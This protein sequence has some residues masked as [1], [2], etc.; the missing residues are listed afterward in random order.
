MVPI[1][2]AR[3]VSPIRLALPHSALGALDRSGLDANQKPGLDQFLQE[4]TANIDELPVF[5]SLPH[6]KA[7]RFGVYPIQTNE[8]SNESKGAVQVDTTFIGSSIAT[9]NPGLINVNTS[10]V[11]LV[12]AAMRTAGMGGLEQIIQARSQGKLANAPSPDPRTGNDEEMKV[13]LTSVSSVWSFRI[14]VEVGPL[15]RSWWAVYVRNGSQWECVQRL[16]IP[17]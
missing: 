12:E 8:S 5:P 4:S 9:H 15:Q 17:E 7:A 16:V 2:A 13:Q 11:N 3:Y 10:P 6:G 14:D 1:A